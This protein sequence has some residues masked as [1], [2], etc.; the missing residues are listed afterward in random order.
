MSGYEAQFVLV[1]AV[2][3]Y[4][5]PGCSRIGCRP[6][7]SCFSTT[8]SEWVSSHRAVSILLVVPVRED[9][10]P[11]CLESP[12]LSWS[13]WKKNNKYIFFFFFFFYITL[14]QNF[15]QVFSGRD[16]YGNFMVASG[17]S[18]SCFQGRSTWNSFPPLL[19]DCILEWRL[20]LFAEYGGILPRSQ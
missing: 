12:V 9:Y 10:I 15:I 16:F 18:K 4:Q 8:G 6:H 3:W 1:A 14:L 13:L 17:L 7:F 19:E 11:V 5:Q 20:M 2:I